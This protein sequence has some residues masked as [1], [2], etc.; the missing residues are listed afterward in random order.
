MEELLTG[1][2]HRVII[3]GVKQWCNVRSGPSLE[4][5]IIGKAYLNDFFNAYAFV[6]DWYLIDFNG[7]PGYI[8]KDFISEVEG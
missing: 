5:K 6:E 4:D 1:K 3:E 8:Y 7:K 2:A